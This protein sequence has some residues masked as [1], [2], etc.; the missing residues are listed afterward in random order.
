M[1]NSDAAV[2]TVSLA[3]RLGASYVAR[4]FSGDKKQV[5]PLVTGA[6]AHEGAA[7]IDIVSPC[8]MDVSPI[9]ST[10]K[11]ARRNNED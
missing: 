2:D 3:L 10:S 6:I 1:V 11:K 5:V 8:V 7:F 9:G 4:S